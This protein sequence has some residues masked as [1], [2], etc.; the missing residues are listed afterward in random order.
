MSINP[1]QHAFPLLGNIH[2]K[3]TTV[4]RTVRIFQL[5]EFGTSSDSTVYVEGARA[6]P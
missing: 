3:L 5:Q 6:A 2:R 4:R 1:T